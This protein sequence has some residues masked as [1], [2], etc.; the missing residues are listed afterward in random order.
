MSIAVSPRDSKNLI[1]KT[2]KVGHIDNYQQNGHSSPPLTLAHI[3]SS[4]RLLSGHSVINLFDI[5][6]DS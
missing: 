2:K 4:S 1:P 5:I 6:T 3:A